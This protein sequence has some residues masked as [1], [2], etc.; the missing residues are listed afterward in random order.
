[1]N[2][3]AA[4]VNQVNGPY[5]METVRLT[6]Q[7]EDEVRVRVVASGICH[8]DEAMRAGDGPHPFPA[9]FG[10]EGAGIVE[11]VG[12]AVR[13]IRVGDHVV[14][15]YAWCGHCPACRHGHPSHCV[16]FHKM[17]SDGLRNDGS[18]LFQRPDGTP[19]TSFFYQSSFATCTQTTARNLIVV[20][21]QLD[22]RLAA[23][24]ACGMLTGYGTVLNALKPRQGSALAVFGSGAVGMAAIMAAKI[25]GCD[26]I[27]AVDIHDARLTLA[28]ELGATHALN[29]TREDPAAALRQLTDGRG[30]DYA[31]DTSGLTAV[32]QTA[33]ESVAIGGTFAPL[34]VARHQ[35]TLNPMRDLIAVNRHIAGVLMG[36]AVPQSDIP[37]LIRYYRQGKF[38]FDKLITFY[39]FADINQAQADSASGLAIKPVLIIDRAYTPARLSG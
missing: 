11:A 18:T 32:M 33:L 31:L 5:Q 12:G 36:D 25:A 15:S 37:Q 23:P 3:T 9:V 35:L 14:M 34:A 16:D 38:P 6:P 26:P 24:L 39:D 29:S 17:N 20:D 13:N 27:V 21:K 28:K 8:S 7:Q 4:V 30:V 22:L 10:H 2:I 1:M 19:V